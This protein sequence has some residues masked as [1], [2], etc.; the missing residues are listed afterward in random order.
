MY[1]ILYF[2]KYIIELLSTNQILL[3]KRRLI[4]RNFQRINIRST[5][6]PLQPTVAAFTL[7][8]FDYNV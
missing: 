8:P 1:K 4:F 5:C 2:V 7:N 6:S 3:V